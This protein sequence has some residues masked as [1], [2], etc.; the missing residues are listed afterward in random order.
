[1]SEPQVDDTWQAMLALN[2]RSSNSWTK[3]ISSAPGIQIRE[4]S[5]LQPSASAGSFSRT[6]MVKDQAP[7][8]VFVRRDNVSIYRVA[9]VQWCPDRV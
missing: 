7:V 2:I 3:P 4:R 9:F 6:T 8:T 1:M 5:I